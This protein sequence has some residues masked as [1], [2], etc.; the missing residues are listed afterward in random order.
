MKPAPDL[1]PLGPVEGAHIEIIGY[2]F[3]ADGWKPSLRKIYRVRYG[4]CGK[5]AAMNQRAIS[6]RK[7]EGSIYCIRC[8][9]LNKA[10]SKREPKRKPTGLSFATGPSW[11]VP[12]RTT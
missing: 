8:A 7:K 1:L 3:S 4:C 11:P 6:A 12:G 2:N 5:E 9:S 10:K